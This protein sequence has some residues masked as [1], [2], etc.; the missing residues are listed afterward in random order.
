MIKY[1]GQKTYAFALQVL[2]FTNTKFLFF[3][4]DSVSTSP[5]PAAL[6]ST[7]AAF[8]NQFGDDEGA[9][10]IIAPG[11]VNLIGEHVDYNDGFVLPMAVSLHT[12]LRLRPRTDDIVD[13]YAV[14]FDQRASFNVNEL[15]KRGDWLD[16]AQAVAQ[17]LQRA[18][19]T[20]GGLEGVIE[21][22]IPTASG[23]SS[24]A[25]IEVGMA[26]AFLHSSGETS[27]P[28]AIAQLC[29]RAENEF[30]GVNCGIM[31]QT[32][33]AACIADHAL[34][35]D[36]RSLE[37][38]QVPLKLGDYCIV[39]ID[40]GAPRELAS[41]AYNERRAQCESG[42][43]VLAAHIPGVQSLRDVSPQQLEAH[44]EELEPVIYQRVRH[45][46]SEIART[47]EAVAVLRQGD[48]ESFG[49][50]MNAS[51]DS[52]RD[53]YAVS[54]RELDWIVDKCRAHDGVLG[55]RMT[56]AGFGGCTIALTKRENAPDLVKNLPREY[57]AATGHTAR[58]WICG[59]ED[60]AR[61]L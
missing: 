60:G 39:V 25:S 20:V 51:H 52:L 13:L 8:Q 44:S 40:S 21:S 47:E 22:N 10:T 30:V 3:M 1:L 32:A 48:L 11:R 17:Q 18:G 12:V 16:Y 58:A 29:Q 33:V 5:A 49:A 59:A 43:Q 38:E 34:L 28:I 50:L 26:Y 37:T 27:D 57:K 4:N 35:L 9:F 56:G 24:S 19:F 53:D 2:A 31:D 61:V 45:V 23:L 41:S 42:L 46:V 7:V 36:C 54:S 14:N 15:D 55:A 6:L